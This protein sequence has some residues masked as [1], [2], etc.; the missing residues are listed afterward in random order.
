MIT[1]NTPSDKYNGMP[2]SYVGTGCAYEDFYC[3]PFLE[4]LPDALKDDG[5]LSLDAANSFIRKHLPIR[6]KTYYKRS[7]RPLLKV[8]LTGNT[9]KYLICVYGHFIY[10]NGEYY[11]SFFNNENDQVV[12]TWEI[13]E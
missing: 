5:Y 9:K 13:K 7:E 12:C 8:F 4:E 11:W 3:K 10:A 6:K 1:R 2:C